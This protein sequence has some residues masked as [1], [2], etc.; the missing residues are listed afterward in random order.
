MSSSLEEEKIDL[1]Q[2]W[3]IGMKMGKLVVLKF[4]LEDFYLYLPL[5]AFVQLLLVEL[6]LRPTMTSFWM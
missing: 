5:A 6:I 3:T 4:Q 1:E 2:R